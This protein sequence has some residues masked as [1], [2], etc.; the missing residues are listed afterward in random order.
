MLGRVRVQN[1][2]RLHEVTTEGTED[3]GGA[4]VAAAHLVKMQCGN[5]D[6]PQ[7]SHS[8]KNRALTDS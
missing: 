5:L 6:T 4:T 1:C 2:R 8:T 3:A 7:K